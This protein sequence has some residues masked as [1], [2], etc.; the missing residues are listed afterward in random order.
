MA[1]GIW[2]DS[3][4][5]EGEATESR[6]SWEWKAVDAIGRVHVWEIKIAT[7]EDGDPAIEGE[8]YLRMMIAYVR[9]R[10]YTFPRRGDIQLLFF[11]AIILEN[12]YEA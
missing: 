10:L 7:G 3:G 11:I 6:S 5:G 8:E 9:I 4:S 2:D 1:G 12:L